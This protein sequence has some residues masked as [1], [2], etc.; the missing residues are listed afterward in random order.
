M[1]QRMANKHPVLHRVTSDV[2][3]NFGNPFAVLFYSPVSSIFRVNGLT[4]TH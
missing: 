2:F 4:N 3:L 1:F